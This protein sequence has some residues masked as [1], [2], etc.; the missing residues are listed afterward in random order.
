MKQAQLLFQRCTQKHPAHK[1]IQCNLE[2]FHHDKHAG[3]MSLNGWNAERETPVSWTDPSQNQKEYIITGA[4]LTSSGTIAGL[5]NS[6]SY[7]AID[8]VQTAWILWL[9]DQPA[10]TFKRLMNWAQAWNAYL[11]DPAN[12]RTTAGYRKY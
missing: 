4:H 12:A 3:T 8:A 11:A 1:E 6:S 5:I 2:L 9:A 7:S 10:H